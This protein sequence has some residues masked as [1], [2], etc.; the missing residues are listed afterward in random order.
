MSRQA[1][2]VVSMIQLRFLV[3]ALGERLRWWPSRFTD[4][5]G[6]RWLSTAFPRTVLRASLES[7]TAVARRNHDL[8]LN[9]ASVHLFRLGNAQ[10]DTIAHHLAQGSAELVAPPASVDEIITALDEL[11]PPNGGAPPVG[12]CS[13]GKERRT[14]FNAAVGDLARVYAAAARAGQRAVPYF[15]V[16]G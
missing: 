7:V 14:R 1:G 8:K 13:L 16:G 2:V 15:E 6:I 11:G 5:I 10:E 4:E 9:P 12:P 3:G